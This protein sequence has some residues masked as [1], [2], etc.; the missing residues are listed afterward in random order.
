[1]GNMPSNIGHQRPIGSVTRAEII[2]ITPEDRCTLSVGQVLHD[3]EGKDAPQIWKQRYWAT[4]RDWRLI[5]RLSL[6]ARL[7][8]NVRR[9]KENAST[10]PW[11]M[12]EG[13]QPLDPSHHP[14]KPPALP[15]PSQ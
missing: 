10:K 1:M 5:D 3:L 8:D 9:A 4:P 14:P 7:R 12:A 2:A 6:Y 15:L 11:L 13:F